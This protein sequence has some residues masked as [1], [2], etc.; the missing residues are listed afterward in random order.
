MSV[1]RDHANGA[2]RRQ[3]CKYYHIPVA[4]PPAN[5]MATVHTTNTTTMTNNNNYNNN[6]NNNFNH[7]ITG[8]LNST[9]TNTTTN[10]THTTTS[11]MHSATPLAAGSGYPGGA[12]ITVV[13]PHD[14][15]LHSIWTKKK[16]AHAIS[17]SL[18]YILFLY[19][20][21]NHKLAYR[22]LETLY[23]VG[24]STYCTSVPILLQN[25]RFCLHDSC[26]QCIIYKV[27]KVE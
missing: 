7:T 19:Q 3:Q 21:D 6:N 4:I 22:L 27:I 24:T 20:N 1:C 23:F 25:A 12:I 13:A 18:V 2:C 26:I 8:C 5:M 16:N 10:V 9:A 15:Q 17:R 14:H 11:L